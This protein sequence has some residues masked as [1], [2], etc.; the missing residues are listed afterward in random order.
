LQV[1]KLHQ[2]NLRETECESDLNVDWLKGFVIE[3]AAVVADTWVSEHR[4]IKNMVVD[5]ALKNA[6]G[7]VLVCMGRWCHPILCRHFF[8]NY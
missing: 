6:F 2:K 7:A 8:R 5:T 3:F 1:T 4:L